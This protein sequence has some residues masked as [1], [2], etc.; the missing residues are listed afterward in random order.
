[1]LAIVLSS[2]PVRLL[3]S[4]GAGSGTHDANEYLTRVIESLSFGK[5][6]YDD[7]VRA[8]ATPRKDGREMEWSAAL[9]LA[10]K[11]ADSD[12][13]DARAQIA[14]YTKNR[15]ERIRESA[16]TIDAA[17]GALL[18]SNRNFENNLKQFL[19]GKVE[20]PGSLVEQLAQM[21][22][23]EHKAWQLLAEGM[24]AVAHAL[25][26]PSPSGKDKITHLTITTEQ[27]QMAL[28]SL[29]RIFGPS[30]RKNIDDMRDDE[31]V[32]EIL[33][34]AMLLHGFLSQPW[35]GPAH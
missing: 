25:V 31:T 26:E 2:H 13:A 3:A 29:E 16:T 34:V 10:Y 8:H 35:E 17:Y 22:A 6:G 33:G 30:V 19:N 20:K 27:R 32:P 12:Y 21:D 18:S 15:N 28:S 23:L 24:A 1:M 7:L 4:E 9:L 11:K 5:T 14:P